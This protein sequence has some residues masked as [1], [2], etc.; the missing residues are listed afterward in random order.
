[1]K[2][3]WFTLIELLVVIAIIAIL[4]SMLLPALNNARDRAK[5]M[6][7][8]SNLKQIG[9]K[10]AFYTNDFSDYVP[11]CSTNATNG[12]FKLF[13]SAGYMAN[14]ELGPVSS[15]PQMRGFTIREGGTQAMS[16][17]ANNFVLP[18]I[19]ADGSVY[20]RSAL[21][22]TGVKW[23]RIHMFKTPSKTFVLMDDYIT[24]NGYPQIRKWDLI[25][26]EHHY[27]ALSTHII[28]S[29]IGL[30]L[31]YLDGHADFFRSK[32]VREAVTKD[33]SLWGIKTW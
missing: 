8:L 32:N 11:P 33:L 19:L 1:M 27:T 18:Y 29:N 2:F 20:D 3:K 17:G 5:T 13:N 9:L 25:L 31:S 14:S 4:A 7:C 10:T 21:I 22:A 6:S 16:Y 30:N 24:W 23:N 28:H 26:E 12:L 15:C